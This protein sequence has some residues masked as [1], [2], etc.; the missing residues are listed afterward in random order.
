MFYFLEGL[1]EDYNEATFWRATPLAIT[2]HKYRLLYTVYLMKV[3][4]SRTENV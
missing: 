4:S 2:T 1:N 3:V